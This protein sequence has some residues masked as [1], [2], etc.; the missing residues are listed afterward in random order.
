MAIEAL[1]IRR[2]PGI[3]TPITID[4]TGESLCRLSGDQIITTASYGVKSKTLGPACD[5][6]PG[7]LFFA[8]RESLR[9]GM[10]I[11]SD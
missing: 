4:L 2:K 9:S 7:I 3:Y 11:N 10:A 6:C 1:P 8:G 5:Q